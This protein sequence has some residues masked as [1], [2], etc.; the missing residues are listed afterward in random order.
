M[1]KNT[2]VES[3]NADKE[4]LETAKSCGHYAMCKIDFLGCGVCASGLEKHY[5]SFYPQ[6]RMDLYAALAEGEI[7]V[8]RKCLEITEGCNLCGKC[9]YNCYFSSELRPSKVM[10]ALKA[11]IADYLNNGGGIVDIPHDGLLV[12]IKKIV[13]EEWAS[14]DPAILAA[15]HHDLCPHV[16]FHQP[17]Y[18][19]LP[20]SKEEIAAL[21]R[22]L[23]VQ[24]VNYVARGNGASS[25]GLAFSD[26]AVLDL[27]RMKTMDFDE[28]NWSVTVGPGVSAFEVQKA[29][30]QRGYRVNTAEPAANVCANIMTSG[31][32]STYAPS[33]G[34]GADNYIDAEFI[35]KDGEY[36]RLNE[37]T[38]PNLFSFQNNLAEP[39]HLAICVSVTIKL[40]PRMSDEA[41]VLVP[42]DSLAKALDFSKECAARRIGLAI[43]ILGREFIST[44]LAPTKGL[45]TDVK[46]IFSLRL[47]M[48]YLVLLTGDTHALRSVRDMGHPLINQKLFKTLY[49]NIPKL[50]SSGWLDMLEGV[51]N[52]QLF[53]YLKLP[54]LP[55]LAEMALG[56]SSATLTRDIDPE[57][58]PFFTKLYAKP[59][60]TNLVWINTFRIYSSRYCRANP[61]VSLVFYLPIDNALIR[62]IQEGFDAIAAKHRVKGE[63]GFITPLDCGKRCVFEYDF[64]FNHLDPEE[65]VRIQE[66]AREAGALLDD[67]DQ[68]T[69]VIRQVRYLVN[70]GCCRTENLLYTTKG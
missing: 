55:D 43:V 56:S 40:H 20:Q 8:T 50:K 58:R 19:V 15:Y 34:I 33:F 57:L 70:R 38:A 66:A 49:L 16:E 13:G 2:L 44:F 9:D 51:S 41:G 26:G 10:K 17:R 42:F 5:V 14:N 7:P 48:P 24:G 62:E 59:E 64:Y 21:I 12:E 69:G 27:S 63:F 11:H 60:L 46:E 36:F 67:Y 53:S 23:R 45:A 6:G 54:Q 47:G 68:K 25:H 32:I 37:L 52:D 61:S 39:E 1:D 22:L 29:A 28:K 30:Q 3:M 18:V 31:L 35:G 65:K 4:I